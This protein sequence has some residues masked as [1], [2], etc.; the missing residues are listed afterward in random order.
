MSNKKPTFVLIHGAWHQPAH[1][2]PLITSLN[3][4]GYKT[5]APAL[6]SVA[7]VQTAP[8]KDINEDTNTVRKSILA[9]LNSGANVI[10]VPH[11]YGGIPTTSALRGLDSAS[12]TAQDRQTSVIAI[13]ALTSFILPEGMNIPEA[14][15]KPMPSGL[16]EIMD[17]PPPELFYNDLG[18]EDRKKWAALLRPMSSGAL[19]G[20]STFSAHEVIPVHYLLADEDRAVKLATQER[21]VNILKA[22]L[23]EGQVRT[24]MLRGCGHS[25]FLSRVEETT[26]FLRKSAGE[27]V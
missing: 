23:V 17:H 18:E 26:A 4:H 24:E 13:T 8:C 7:N 14:D 20:R 11:S 16:P 1:W 19:F 22:G 15:Q 3:A 10:V 9:E 12:R 6:P 5:I 2:D 27:N 21:M 25:P